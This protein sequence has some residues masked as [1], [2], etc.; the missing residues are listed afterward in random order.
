[1]CLLMKQ[2][3]WLMKQ[4]VA[5]GECGGSWGMWSIMDNVVTHSEF[6][7][8]WGMWRLMEE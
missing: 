8:S 3:T 7:G 2:V 1:M 5:Y 6:G 4:V